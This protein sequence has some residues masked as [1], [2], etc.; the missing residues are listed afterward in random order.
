MGMVFIPHGHMLCNLY[1][2]DD[3]KEQ[4]IQMIQKCY[5]VNRKVGREVGNE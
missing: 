1:F 2:G 3:K 5:V 4:I